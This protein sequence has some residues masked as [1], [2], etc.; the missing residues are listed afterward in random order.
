MPI[1]E[2]TCD[3]CGLSFEQLLASSSA[4]A[5]CPECGSSKVTKQFSAF[6]AHQGGAAASPCGRG[7]TPPCAVGMNCPS[8][9]CRR[10]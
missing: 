5:K 4:K 9:Q 3:K 10:R 6:A 8:G 2:Y 1:Y 7:D